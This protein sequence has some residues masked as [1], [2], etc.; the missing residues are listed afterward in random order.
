MEMIGGW[1]EGLH[2]MDNLP[3]VIMSAI[4]ETM[5][6]SAI[7]LFIYSLLEYLRVHLPNVEFHLA[8]PEA[9][10]G[11]SSEMSTTRPSSGRR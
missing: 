11:T 3:Y 1:Y 8:S 10:S 9:G 2:G 6:M 5:E 4:E 7:V